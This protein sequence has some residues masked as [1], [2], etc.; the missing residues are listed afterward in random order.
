M[1]LLVAALTDEEFA[2]LGALSEKIL[3]AQGIKVVIPNESG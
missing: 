2:Q 3:A 1:K